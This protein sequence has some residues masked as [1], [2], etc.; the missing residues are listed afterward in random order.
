MHNESLGSANSI[1]ISVFRVVV[2][3]H[4]QKAAE[5]TFNWPI[6]TCLVGH[7]VEFSVIGALLAWTD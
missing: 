1:C 2:E 4:V 5:S 7:Q 6:K 3:H